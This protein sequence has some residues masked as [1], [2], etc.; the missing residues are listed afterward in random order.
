MVRAAFRLALRQAEGLIASIFGLLGVALPVPDHRQEG[1]R[2][3][4][5]TSW[6]T[7]KVC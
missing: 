4:D 3:G 7:P 6:S 2:Q 1:Q 5:A